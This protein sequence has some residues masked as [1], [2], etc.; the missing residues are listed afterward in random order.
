MKFEWIW[1]E[2]LDFDEIW[3]R[4]SWLHLDDTSN[5]DKMFEISNEEYLTFPLGFKLEK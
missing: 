5:V 2:L 3:L 1:L 4:G